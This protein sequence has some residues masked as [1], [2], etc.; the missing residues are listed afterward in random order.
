V[1]SSSIGGCVVVPATRLTPLSHSSISLA[2]KY[3]RYVGRR[4]I[5]VLKFKHET[6]GSLAPELVC[7]TTLLIRTPNRRVVKG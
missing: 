1:R 4:V 7:V 3:L 6:W 5:L 2:S